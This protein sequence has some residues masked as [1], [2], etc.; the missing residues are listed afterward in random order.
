MNGK[1]AF[2]NFPYQYGVVERTYSEYKSGLL[3]KTL[4]S[5]Y[6]GLTAD[7][8]A[9]AVKA[10]FDGAKG[11]YSDGTARHFSRQTWHVPAKTDVGCN[12]AGTPTPTPTPSATG[13]VMAQWHIYLPLVIR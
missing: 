7:L 10:A 1:A 2:K 5:S 8:K 11:N 6:A 4:V 12:K 13:A 3:S 9:G